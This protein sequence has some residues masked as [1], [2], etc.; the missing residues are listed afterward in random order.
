V[1]ESPSAA[2]N[3]RINKAMSNY[4]GWVIQDHI[5]FQFGTTDRCGSSSSSSSSESSSS[6]SSS[7]S[8]SESA[9]SSCSQQWIDVLGDVSTWIVENGTAGGSAIQ[10]G[11]GNQLIASVGAGNLSDEWYT[12]KIRLQLFSSGT[13]IDSIEVRDSALNV[14]V[15]DT[16]LDMSAGGLIYFEYD[17]SWGANDLG[18]ITIE[19]GSD[20]C[21]LFQFEFWE[22]CGSSSSKS[23]SSE[24]SALP[25]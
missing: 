8:L 2:S 18:G 5:D 19:G 14:L 17:V 15:T 16:N 4:L 11:T 12:Q 25:A 7:S 13:V 6:E 3:T 1:N 24:S 22:D 10:S 20:P 21:G 9:S 23:S